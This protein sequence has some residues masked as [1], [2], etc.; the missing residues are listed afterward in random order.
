[1]TSF[2]TTTNVLLDLKSNS[3]PE[4]ENMTKG[5]VLTNSVHRRFLGFKEILVNISIKSLDLI[6]YF[7]YMYEYSIRNL[8]SGKL[9]KTS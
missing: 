7:S 8:L 4:L 2:I 3:L 1:M 9:S 6:S 5:C